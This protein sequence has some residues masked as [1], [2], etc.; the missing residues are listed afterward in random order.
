MKYLPFF[1]FILAKYLELSW[2]VII[3]HKNILQLVRK[4]FV[5]CST[6]ELPAYLHELAG[7]DLEP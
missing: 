4:K 3:A 5:I 2:L 1:E 6:W 7:V